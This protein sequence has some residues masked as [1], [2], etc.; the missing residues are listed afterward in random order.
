MKG[1]FYVTYKWKLPIW[2]GKPFSNPYAIECPNKDVMVDCAYDLNSIH[3]LNYLNIN[4]CGR[5]P[6][7]CKVISYE[8]Y[9]N[10]SWYNM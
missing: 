1:K 8:D 2:E 3:G 7:N 10:G 5:L 4:T 9:K 6:K